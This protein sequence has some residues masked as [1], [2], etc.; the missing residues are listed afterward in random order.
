MKRTRFS[1]RAKQT[2][3]TEQ[4]IRLAG[5]L[6]QS[7]SRI[8]DAFWEARLATLVEQL[9][10]AGDEAAINAAL[11]HLYGAGGRAYDEL[12]DMVES[13]SEIRRGESADVLM[14]AVPV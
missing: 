3:D 6:S 9:L 8:E 10:T 11:D 5:T 2:P 1:R 4:L 12:A 7:G 14:F 13:C